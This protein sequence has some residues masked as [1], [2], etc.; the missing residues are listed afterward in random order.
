MLAEGVNEQRARDLDNITEQIQNIAEIMK[1]YTDLAENPEN[2]DSEPISFVEVM[3]R[4]SQVYRHILENAG[5]TLKLN[6]VDDLPQ[7]CIA[8]GRLTQV[9]LNL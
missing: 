4:T 9:I 1:Q 7:V 5:I 6:L 2:A 3:N 8:P